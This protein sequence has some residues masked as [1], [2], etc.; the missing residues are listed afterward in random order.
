MSKLV[1]GILVAGAVGALATA[2]IVVGSA[3]KTW[4]ASKSK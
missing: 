2:T 1:T 4:R 3:I